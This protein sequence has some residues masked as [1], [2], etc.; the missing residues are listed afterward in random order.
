MSDAIRAQLARI[1]ASPGFVA[2][3]R[4][5]PFLTFL[6]ER[7]LAGE[8]LKESV[9][10]V[11]LFGRAADYD[12]RLDPIVRVEA[13]RLRSRL[14]EYYEGA[15]AGDAVVI[16]LPK[17]TYV[18][19]FRTRELP[20]P[21]AAATKEA[22]P[23]VSRRWGW[24]L[25]PA[26]AAVLAVGAAIGLS[27]RTPPAPAAVAV[28]PFLNLSDS[29]AN[30]SFSEG[31][32]E[33]IIDR[34]ARIRG[35][36]V[37][38]RSSSFRFKGS[39]QDLREVGRQLN[40]TSVVEG[41]VRRAGD[42]LRITAQLVNVADGFQLWSQTYERQTKDVFEIQ[43]DVARAVANA[44]R[45]ELRVGFE[46]RRQPPTA[47]PEAHDLYLE[48]RY[49]LNHDAIAGLELAADSFARATETDPRYAEAQ[50]ALAETY[51]LLAYYRLR[52]PEEAWPLARTAAER[53]LALDPLLAEAHAARGLALA[54]DEWQWAEAEPHFRRAVELDPAS[55]EVRIAL[56]WGLLLPRGLTKEAARN[57]DEAVALDPNSSLAHQL[58]SFVLLVEGRADAAVASYRRTVELNPSNG[59]MQWDLGMALAYA[60]QKE[61]AMRQFRVGGNVHTGGDW[62]PGPT[63]YALLGEPEKA[64]SAIARWPRFHEQ[65]PIFVAYAYA[66]LGDAE[67]AAVWLDRAREKRDPQVVW[68]KVDPR[69][70]KVRQDPRIQAVIRKIGL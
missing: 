65:R 60:G 42:R 66:L 3:G 52:P 54:H 62:Q 69:L 61:A 39:A 9:V 35:L 34:L 50:A 64:R 68:A 6:V 38:A 27:R 53:A 22:G 37:V 46:A 36:R 7:A 26:A 55:C 30:A 4:L 41:S 67:N 59:D 40:A 8:P 25:A 49:H 23:V 2:A 70:A 5:A 16:E 13:R 63:E 10:G 14:A 1:V 29:A 24:G 12:P 44:L 31:L 20:S 57:A 33:E 43:D 32:A 19:V 17:G 51:A 28:L 21:A 56:V 58:R 47:N 15:G 48:G 18:P 45:V 11:E